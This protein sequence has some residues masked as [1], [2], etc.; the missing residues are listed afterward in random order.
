VV[1]EDSSGLQEGRLMRS[2]ATRMA[3]DAVVFMFGLRGNHAQCHS[4]KF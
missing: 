4:A 1:V 3:V 2:E